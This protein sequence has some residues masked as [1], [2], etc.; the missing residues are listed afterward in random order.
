M[1]SPVAPSEFKAL[2]PTGSDTI[3]QSL[4][5]VVIQ[6]PIL[7]WRWFSYAHTDS[8]SINTPFAQDLCDTISN[9]P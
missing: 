4:V 1:P 3:C 7:F 6:F 9:C 8:G 5:K 2:I